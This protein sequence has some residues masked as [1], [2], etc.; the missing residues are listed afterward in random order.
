[1]IHEVLDETAISCRTE[2]HCVTADQLGVAAFPWQDGTVRPAVWVDMFGIDARAHGQVAADAA[3]FIR[4]AVSL[5]AY[6]LL[7]IP[8]EGESPRYLLPTTQAAF[9][10]PQ[11]VHAAPLLPQFRAILDRGAVASGPQL[12]AVLHDVANKIDADL[13]VGH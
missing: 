5:P 13:P 3:A 9:D 6:R 1:M 11:I 4:Y 10:D 7:L 8:T 12:N 2:E